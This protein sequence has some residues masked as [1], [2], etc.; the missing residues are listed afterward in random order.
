ML[1]TTLLLSVVVVDRWSWP[2]PLMVAI[3]LPLLVL[4][5]CFVWGNALKIGHGGWAPLVIAGIACQLMIVWRTGERTLGIMIRSLTD[6]LERFETR[7]KEAS[8][9]R[10]PGTGVFLSRTGEMPPL[11]LTRAVDSLGT[12]HERAVLVTIVNERIPRVRTAQRLTLEDRGNGLYLVQLRYGFMQVP[13]I[14]RALR[15]ATFEG[16]PI[17]LDKVTYFILHHFTL[18]SEAEGLRAWRQRLFAALER[19]FE[20]AQ[21]DNIPSERV[22]TVGIP[23][24]LPSKVSQKHG[25]E[26]EPKHVHRDAAGGPQ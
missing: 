18:V 17:D 14:P 25:L 9:P 3:V 7:L 24:Y 11:V 5:V 10:V 21:H 22:F 16:E 26:L 23:L 19:N 6:S 13:D 15:L 4:D 12:L 20:G 2:V 1:I 8:L